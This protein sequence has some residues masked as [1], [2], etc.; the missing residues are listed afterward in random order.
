MA[1]TT[2]KAFKVTRI[3]TKAEQR[4]EIAR[5]YQLW[6][7]WNR[8]GKPYTGE[9]R[10]IDLHQ[11][12]FCP[13]C[14]DHP[15]LKLYKPSALKGMPVNHRYESV[16]CSVGYRQCE[17]EH[18]NIEGRRA[19]GEW[20][21]EDYQYPLTKLEMLKSRKESLEESRIRNKESIKSSEKNIKDINVKLIALVSEIKELEQLSMSKE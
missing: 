19:V 18:Q 3:L 7:E 20:W 9:I 5:F 17:Y 21:S 1:Q 13:Q 14:R 4:E 11:E 10:E 8:L 2:R 16:Y 6:I 15:P 12:L